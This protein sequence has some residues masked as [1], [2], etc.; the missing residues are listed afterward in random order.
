VL[1]VDR[2]NQRELH[3]LEAGNPPLKPGVF[4]GTSLAAL[5]TKRPRQASLEGLNASELG[6]ATIT[7]EETDQGVIPLVAAILV[8]IAVNAGYDAAKQGWKSLIWSGVEKRL[9]GLALGEELP[10][11]DAKHKEEPGSA[12]DE[13][14][15]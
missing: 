4:R 13:P 6:H 1:G 2:D 9:G 15:Q 11:P 5:K 7:V 3:P 14:E 8:G 10:Q 12:A